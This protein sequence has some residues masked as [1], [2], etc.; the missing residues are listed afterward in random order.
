MS[1]PKSFSMSFQNLTSASSVQLH[2]TSIKILTRLHQAQLDKDANFM[3]CMNLSSMER[4]IGLY[5][6]DYRLS[7]VFAMLATE[8]RKHADLIFKWLFGSGGLQILLEIG[9]FDERFGDE[10]CDDEDSS[11][12]SHQRRKS[13]P[14]NRGESFGLRTYTT[15]L[16]NVSNPLLALQGI[17]QQRAFHIANLLELKAI[18]EESKRN[19]GSKSLMIGGN[20]SYN[21]VSG[22][23]Q[24][25]KAN[26]RGLFCGADE[27]DKRAREAIMC[28]EKQRKEK[29]FLPTSEF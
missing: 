27:C 24:F 12:T 23:L 4:N 16:F 21:V 3:E 13:L 10:E 11:E 5:I 17:M 20:E 15:P 9:Y 18:A 25:V 22:F 7:D 14:N 26:E 29:Q 2:E 28:L 8:E 6:G 19:S 1:V